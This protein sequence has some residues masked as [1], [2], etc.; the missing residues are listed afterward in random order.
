MKKLFVLCMVIMT[1]LLLVGCNNEEGIPDG[2]VVAVCVQGN[3]FQYI[4]KDD[5]V[6]E[7][8]SDSVL[9]NDDM[10]AVVQSSVDAIGTVR[11]YIDTTFQPDVC[12]FT[13]YV[14]PA[15]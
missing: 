11:E 15:E 6:Y 12:T 3:T 7:F 14:E 13:D 10:L 9:Q 2:A 1:S 4:Y 8:Y 5:V